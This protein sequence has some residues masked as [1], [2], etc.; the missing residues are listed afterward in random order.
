MKL[1]FSNILPMVSGQIVNCFLARNPRPALK[2]ECF[3]LYMESDVW[4]YYNEL[5]CQPSKL[6]YGLSM[7]VGLPVCCIQ[8]I[9]G[10]GSR[11][12]FVLPE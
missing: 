1:L 9:C 2:L 11:L 12:S 10:K 5:F 4:K 3:T 6:K 7:N 8:N